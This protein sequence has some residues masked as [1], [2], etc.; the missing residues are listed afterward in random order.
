MKSP[1]TLAKQY[2]LTQTIRSNTNILYAIPGADVAIDLE[3]KQVYNVRNEP[4]TINLKMQSSL[5]EI[6]LEAFLKTYLQIYGKGKEPSEFGEINEFIEN[7]YSGTGT[8]QADETSEFAE[9][10]KAIA[11]YF[12]KSEYEYAEQDA[13]IEEHFRGRKR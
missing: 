2:H 13:F 5:D 1:Q 12:S 11:A 8:T 9:Q 7:Y 4:H 10:D 3:N 6:G